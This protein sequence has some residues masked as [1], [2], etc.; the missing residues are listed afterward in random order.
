MVAVDGPEDPSI[1]GQRGAGTRGAVREDKGVI[2]KAESG[3]GGRAQLLHVPLKLHQP[4]EIE[5]L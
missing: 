1:L 5:S 4:V 3:S 2:R